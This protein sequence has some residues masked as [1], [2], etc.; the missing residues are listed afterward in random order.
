MT[1]RVS[2]VH[3]ARESE[4]GVAL[5]LVIWVLALLAALA[6]GTTLEVRAGLDVTRGLVDTSRTR[7]LADSGIWAA[8]AMLLDERTHATLRRDGTPQK[9]PAAGDAVTVEIEDERAKFD[10]NSVREAPLAKLF[11]IVGIEPTLARDLV[12][13]RGTRKPA[14][15]TLEELRLVPGFTIDRFERVAPFLT[16]LTDDWRINPATARPEVLLALPDADAAER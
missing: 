15:T 12:A 13:Y 9:V 2:T 3:G 10:I 14:F 11:Q 6:A 8:V 5:L 1:T 16:V 7:A 4:S